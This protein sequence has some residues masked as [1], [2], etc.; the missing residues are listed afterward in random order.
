MRPYEP[1]HVRQLDAHLRREKRIVLEPKKRLNVMFIGAGKRM[2]L[3]ERFQDAAAIEGIAVKMY[4][5]EFTRR[6]P[7]AALANIVVGPSFKTVESEQFLL[8]AARRLE[9]DI[10]IPNIDPATVLLSKL[11]NQLADLRIWAVVSNH[12][13][14]VSMYDKVKAD[15]WF[16]NHGFAV[17]GGDGY[18][19]IVKMRLGSGAKDQLIANSEE[20]IR[21]FLIHRNREDYFIQP[22]ITGQ[23]Y[24][25]DSYVARSGCT[26]GSLSRKRLVVID[27]EVDVSETS[28]HKEILRSATRVLSVEGW[29]GPI[30]LQFIDGPHGPV[31]IE[32]NP[33]FGGGVT[34]SIHC[35]LDMPRWILRERLDLPVGPVLDWPDGSFMTRCRKDIFL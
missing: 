17:P 3:L 32:I 4:S 31:L 12:D 5:V 8:D 24:T 2:S 33:R 18:P 29:E 10:I 30:T 28:H 20:E 25:V 21:A 9:I 16:R 11:K 15:L 27:G 19:Q 34:H 23:E 14:C 6:V 7:I 26:L 13:L 22:Y 35:G 1:A